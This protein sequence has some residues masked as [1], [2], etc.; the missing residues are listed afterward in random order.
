MV[1]RNVVFNQDDTNTLKDTAIIYDEVMSEGK[2]EKII[3]NLQNNIKDV[4][5]PVNEKSEDQETSINRSE[6]HQRPKSPINIPL[7]QSDDKAESNLKPQDDNQ[8]ST[9]KYRCGQHARP[10]RGHYKAMNEV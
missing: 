4:E 7:P 6:P 2:K 5:K 8:L 9:Q 3:Q 10:E 1:E